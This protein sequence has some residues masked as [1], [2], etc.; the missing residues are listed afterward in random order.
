MP[1]KAA[2]GKQ[3]AKAAQVAGAKRKS[4]GVSGS[5]TVPAPPASNG[6]ARR[7]TAAE[8]LVE[9]T[10]PS[11]N[12]RL[13]I[14]RIE[15]VGG[16][17][18]SKRAKPN[19]DGT[20]VQAGSNNNFSAAMDL[21]KLKDYAKLNQTSLQGI[22]ERFDRLRQQVQTVQQ[23]ITT[24]GNVEQIAQD[25]ADT[26]Q[27]VEEVA[28]E[29][30]DTSLRV[31][32]LAQEAVDTSQRV[33]ELAQDA[34]DTSQRVEESVVQSA[35]AL[36]RVESS[37]IEVTEGQIMVKHLVQGVE[38]LAHSLHGAQLSDSDTLDKIETRVRKLVARVDT[39]NEI[40]AI[41]GSTYNTEMFTASYVARFNMLDASVLNS[42]NWLSVVHGKIDNVVEKVDEITEKCELEGYEG[43]RVSVINVEETVYNVEET[44]NNVKETITTVQE[45]VGSVEEAVGNVA[46]T[47][48][49]IEETVNNLEETVGELKE[50]IDE[51]SEKVD[52]MDT[53]MDSITAALEKADRVATIRFKHIAAQ[54]EALLAPSGARITTR[55]SGRRSQG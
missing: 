21:D 41:R 52:G 55:A 35:E 3:P 46:E 49:K 48:E 36:E 22:T 38:T 42:H 53:K 20:V 47:T 34:V 18:A 39:S 10:Q 26:A 6:T 32:E 28:Q 27:R 45:T 43:M 5:G 16:E 19:E 54:L 24:V 40:H 30:V 9:T 33:E 12:D 7:L 29:A 11:L 15:A 37:I 44:A 51:I 1:P 2:N 13:A 25:S 50:K 8:Q 31:E 23:S 17:R 14:A 4:S